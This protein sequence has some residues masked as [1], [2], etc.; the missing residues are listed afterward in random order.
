M[1]LHGQG[2]EKD[3]K[4]ALRYFKAAADKGNSDAQFNLG[5]MYF[6][7]PFCDLFYPLHFLFL[8]SFFFTLRTRSWVVFS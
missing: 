2:V 4:K 7:E 5:A 6:G 3:M 8:V 1:Y